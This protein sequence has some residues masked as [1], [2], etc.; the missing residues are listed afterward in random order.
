M[1]MNPL[2]IINCIYCKLSK[3]RR[4]IKR[5]QE[6][7]F[8]N[9]SCFIFCKTCNKQLFQKK[10]FCN[11]SCSATFTNSV[12]IIDRSYI[13]DTWRKNISN[14]NKQNWKVGKLTYSQKRLFSS[15]KEREIVAHFKKNFPND[16]WKSGGR[17]KLNSTENISRDMW[18]D[19]LKICFEY[20]GIWHFKDIYG[21][22][23]KKQ[24]KDKLLEQWCIDNNYRL[25]RVDE[26][27]YKNVQQIEE[28]IYS[29]Q[30]TI[31][32]IGNRY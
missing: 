21:Q 30:D 11:N 22:L 20:D 7:C 28:L 26:D 25:I 3:S 16:R 6:K 9:P 17:L 2:L 5:H 31:V 32:K 14:K 1:C 8:Y 23:N 13:T 29:N 18:S 27:C 12:R 4:N 10:K 15:R 19:A 24:N